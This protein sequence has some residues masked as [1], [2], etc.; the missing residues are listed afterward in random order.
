[1]QQAPPLQQAEPL[2]QDALAWLMA[3]GPINNIAAT[4]ESRILL[5]SILL[6]K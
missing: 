6:K 4:I 1:L 3:T 2:Q 5:I